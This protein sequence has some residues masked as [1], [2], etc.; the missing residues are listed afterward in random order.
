MRGIHVGND[1]TVPDSFDAEWQATQLRKIAHHLE[2][3]DDM[4]L[5]E[6]ACDEL[7]EIFKYVE[8]LREYSGY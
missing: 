1:I 7:K 6:V 4:N 3:L 2:N 5:D 8:V